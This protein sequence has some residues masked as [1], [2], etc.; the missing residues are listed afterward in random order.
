MPPF[1]IKKL[2]K[3]RTKIKLTVLFKNK[4]ATLETQ[5]HTKRIT[6]H[7]SQTTAFRFLRGSLKYKGDKVKKEPLL[8]IVNDVTEKHKIK[9][10]VWHCRSGVIQETSLKTSII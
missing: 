6:I 10:R 2:T 8:Q 3:L 4:A 7:Q 5:K 9:R 1:S